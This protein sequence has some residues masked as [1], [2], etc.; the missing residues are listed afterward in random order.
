MDM[1]EKNIRKFSN[2]E[3]ERILNG[4]EL[5]T[6]PSY[7][8]GCYS[9]SDEYRNFLDELMRRVNN[10]VD[11]SKV[12]HLKEMMRDILHYYK[13]KE[14]YLEKYK[15]FLDWEQVIKH[16]ILSNK[17]I[18]KYKNNWSWC[19]ICSNQ[20]LSEQFIKKYFKNLDEFCWAEI[21]SRKGNHLS[22]KFMREFIDYLQL[23][24]VGECYP[25]SKEFLREFGD[26]I[27]F[28]NWYHN[29]RKHETMTQEE[30]CEFMC[31][32]YDKNQMGLKIS[33]VAQGI[34]YEY[35]PY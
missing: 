26:R 9:Y 23:D 20:N 6:P 35:S 24:F 8:R 33:E 27:C 22:E 7:N 17:F 32:Y 4:E 10:R 34:N 13:I 1:M 11:I 30:T 21:S 15:D 14:E 19:D 5:F 3:W 28:G 29:M 18:E 25:I 16:Q 2:K 12:A 31:G